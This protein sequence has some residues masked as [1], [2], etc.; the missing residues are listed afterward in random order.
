[1]A[2]PIV[3]QVRLAL[4]AEAR[5]IAVLQQRSLA[6]YGLDAGLSLE[7]MSQAWLDAI[8]RPPLATFRVLVAIEAEA[9][10]IVGFAAVGPSDDEDAE[11]TDGLVGE[12]VVDADHRRRGHGSRLMHACADTLRADG[13]ERATWWLLTTDDV[14]RTF[15]E[16]AGWAPDGAYRELGTQDAPVVKQIRLH[17][18]LRTS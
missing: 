16:S 11:P 8:L 4:P 1:M 12:F 2:G 14:K 10:G 3:D 15:L 17:T 6:E 7:E 9:G 18:D 13:F 5:S